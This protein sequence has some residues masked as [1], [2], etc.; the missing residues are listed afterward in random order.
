MKFHVDLVI[1]TGEQSVAD[2]PVFSISV[3]RTKVLG[4]SADINLKR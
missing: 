2:C 3:K 1:I 4:F